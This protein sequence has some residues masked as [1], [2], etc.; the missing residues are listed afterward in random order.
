MNQAENM[1]FNNI[2]LDNIA[3]PSVF[4]RQNENV[5]NSYMS[6]IRY[7]KTE[8]DISKISVEMN[9]QHLKHNY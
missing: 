2:F 1:N 5:S 7:V 9:L 8:K 3:K 6:L 4:A